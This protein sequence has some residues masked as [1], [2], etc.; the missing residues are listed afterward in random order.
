MQLKVV[1]ET[2]VCCKIVPKYTSTVWIS[3][4]LIPYT[5]NV[6]ESH[7]RPLAELRRAMR[8]NCEPKRM[9][10][11]F[12]R[13]LVTRLGVQRLT[14]NDPSCVSLTNETHMWLSSH[15]TSCG[16]LSSSGDGA[17]HYR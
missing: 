9:N 16:S 14:L 2:I 6:T 4:K 15:V 8:V 17:T 1:I 12:P 13:M 3:L 11:S 7:T 5:V 10:I